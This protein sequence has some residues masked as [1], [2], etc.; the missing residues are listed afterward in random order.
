MTAGPSE[1]DVMIPSDTVATAVLPD[2]HSTVVSEAEAGVTDAV[3][4]CVF[5]FPVI[6]TEDSERVMP[7]TETAAASTV[8]VHEAVNVPEDVSAAVAEMTAVPAFMPVTVPPETDAVVSSRELHMTDLF[9]ALSGVTETVS[10]FAEPAVRESAVLLSE[11]PET[12]TVSDTAVHFAY[13]VMSAVT[14]SGKETWQPEEHA[15]SVNQ[16]LNVYPGNEGSDAGP[17]TVF[18]AAA[19][20]AETDDPP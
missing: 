9:E 8:T 15:L 20:S 5:P 16:P 6:V 4:V 11:I 13:S 2:V 17:A 3:S 14:V 18:P 1:T 19:D 12:L 7:V 10:V